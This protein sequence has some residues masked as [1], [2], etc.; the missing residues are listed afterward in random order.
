MK[1]GIVI[2]IVLMMTILIADTITYEKNSAIG[3]KEYY[4]QQVEFDGITNGKVFYTY[5]LSKSKSNDPQ[6]LG[7]IK[8]SDTSFTNFTNSLPIS[9][10]QILSIS[11][12]EGKPIEFDCYTDQTGPDHTG[13]VISETDNS[14][15]VTRFGG[16]LIMA[17]AGMLYSNVSDDCSDCDLGELQSF[18][19]DSQ[20]K[21]QIAYI[22]IGIG[23]LLIALGG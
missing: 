10:D 1:K 19:K 9:C 13:P 12:N 11:D 2:V 22:L 21:Q 14:N 6:V 8:Y 16:I 3:Y 18:T 17:G 4:L 23:G 7:N 5:T 15:V 20:D